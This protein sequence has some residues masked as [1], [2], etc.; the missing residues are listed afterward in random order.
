[1]V[2]VLFFVI[3]MIMDG[4]PAEIILMPILTPIAIS[5]GIQPIHF[6]ILVVAN[7]GL[8][9]AHPP[10]GLCL[11]TACAVAKI[12]LEKAIRPLLPF[13][14]IQ[15]VTLLVITYFEDFTMV[16]PRAL[17]LVK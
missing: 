2:Q 1:M 4:V 6:G 3:G 13:I 17:D 7:V 15:W 9:L 16:L 12:P 8:G 10:V 11:N 14:A 5:Y